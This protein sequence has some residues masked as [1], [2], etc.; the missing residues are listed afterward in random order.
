MSYKITKLQNASSYPNNPLPSIIIKEGDN[1]WPE[2][3]QNY[4][5]GNSP[6]SSSEWK[7]GCFAITES[8]STF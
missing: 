1:G 8:I 7:K 2:A 3:L 6:T 4:L 5:K